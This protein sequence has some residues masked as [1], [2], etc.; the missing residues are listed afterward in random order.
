[1]A[2]RPLLVSGDLAQGAIERRVEE[3]RVVAEAVRAARLLGDAALDDAVRF[4]DD[5]A[6]RGER[7]VA[8]ESGRARDEPLLRQP[9]TNLRELDRVIGPFPARRVH[10][11]D[12]A[13]RVDLQTGVIGDAGQPGRRRIVERLEARILS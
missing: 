5:L 10:A 3:D 9:F 12:T 6:V 7:D 4:E 8:D 13:E 1:M 11:G 2:D